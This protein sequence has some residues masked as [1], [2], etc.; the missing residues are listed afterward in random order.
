MNFSLDERLVADTFVIGDMAL[1]RL[2]L[3][4]DARWPWLILAPRRE[5]VVELTDLDSVDRARLIEEAARAAD[6][7][8]RHTNA[9]KINLGA[10]GNVVRQFHLHVVARTIDD[11]AW[12][13]PVWGLGAARRYAEADALALIEAVK[14]GLELEGPRSDRKASDCRGLA[15]RGDL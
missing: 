4:N 13:G 5:G 14:N 10:L 11:A 12:P 3:M 7:L 8:K 2:L 6:F 1:S 15:E 9:R